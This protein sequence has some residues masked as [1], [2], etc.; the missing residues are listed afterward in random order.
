MK[1]DYE[2]VERAIHYIR[3]NVDQQPD[4]KEVAAHVGLSPYHFQR[5]FQRWAGVTPKRFLEYLTVEQA[6]IL[7]EDSHSI[8][9]VS[10]E[11][12]LPGPGRL[13]DQFVS[14]EA[15]SPGEFKN[16]GA[17][18]EISYSFHD[19]PFGE[20]LLSLTARGILALSFVDPDNRTAEL[21]RLKEAWCNARFVEEYNRGKQLVAQLF[22][23]D[24][25]ERGKLLLSIRGTNFQVKV[26]NALLSI[27]AGT[28]VSYQTIA[29]RLQRPRAVR[30]VANAIG[31]NPVAYLIPCHRALRSSGELGG[32][33]WGVERKRLMLGREQ[34]QA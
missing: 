31:A 16:R 32:Y 4:L 1:A 13:H 10:I 18:L 17:N 7:L 22:D 29:N 6:K 11:T 12:G 34:A 28:I 21:A 26:W 25:S 9:D 14:I 20:L 5:L 8:L 15:V 19:S 23:N 2:R 24:R 30:A 33:R 27:P 3:Q